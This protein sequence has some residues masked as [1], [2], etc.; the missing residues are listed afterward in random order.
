MLIGRFHGAGVQ[1]CTPTPEQKGG[2]TEEPGL[3][4]LVDEE[5]EGGGGQGSEVR[6]R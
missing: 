6:E 4:D 1:T 2:V 3:K 5:G